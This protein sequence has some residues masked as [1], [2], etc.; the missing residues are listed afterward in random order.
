MKVL[1]IGL[2]NT[3]FVG[4]QRGDLI[5]RLKLYSKD[6]RIQKIYQ[7]CY[8]PNKGYKTIKIGRKILLIPTNSLAKGF[9]PIDCNILAKNLDFDI[10]TSQDVESCGIAGMLVKIARNKPL[11]CNF[12]T[13]KPKGWFL[14]KI[15]KVVLKACNLV[16]VESTTQKD[17]LIKSGFNRLII[18][19]PLG[20]DLNKFKPPQKRKAKNTVLFV[21]R[22]S[23]EKNIPMII[24][25]AKIMSECK[26]VIV[27]SG[28]EEAKLKSLAKRLKNV[29]FVGAVDHDKLK[30]YFDGANMLV[31]TSKFEGIPTCIIEGMSNGLPVISTDLPDVQAIITNNKEG[32]LIGQDDVDSLID[33]INILVKSPQQAT[34]MGNAGRRR[35]LSLFGGD[36]VVKT[37]VDGWQSVLQK[38]G[39]VDSNDHVTYCE[40]CNK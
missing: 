21:G 18:V 10:I 1:S 8:T 23:P 9:F 12:F 26:F 35:V 40:E 14:N 30:P 22:L 32:F 11:I 24:K 25:A 3:A 37:V 15:E 13:I 31:L 6:N 29:K 27:G 4:E 34:I 38:S 5:N 20:F 36:N 16:R 7:I 28:T 39:C 17:R 33:R 19:A 2:D